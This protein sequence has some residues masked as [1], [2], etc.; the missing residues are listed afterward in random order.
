MPTQHANTVAA[1]L[2]ELFQN[3][4]QENYGENCTQLE[5]ASQCAQL[6]INDRKDNEVI[7]AAYLHDIGHLLPHDEE[8]MK[9]LGAIDHESTGADYLYQL[10]FSLRVVEMIRNHV[11][12]K[13]YLASESLVYFEGLS[14]ASRVTLEYQGGKMLEDEARAFEQ[15][16]FFEESIALRKYDD[17][18]KVPDLKIHPKLHVEMERLIAEHLSGTV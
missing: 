11:K 5:H 1:E 18:G 7:I 6:A 9:G 3:R 14:K 10:G 8:A 4:G 12:C 16:S 15:S 2:I 13:R 17:V